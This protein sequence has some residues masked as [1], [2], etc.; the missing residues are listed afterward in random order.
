LDPDEREIWYKL[1]LD[2]GLRSAHPSEH[3]KVP[4][5]AKSMSLIAEQFID[6]DGNDTVDGELQDA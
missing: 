6:D 3:Q 2:C 1:Y 5:W 4:S